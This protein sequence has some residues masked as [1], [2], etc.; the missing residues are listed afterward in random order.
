[1]LTRQLKDI[2]KSERELNVRHN[3][4]MATFKEKKIP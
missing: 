1:M 4:I 2:A 3:V